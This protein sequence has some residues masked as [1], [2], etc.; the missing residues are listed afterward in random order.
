MDQAAKTV[1]KVFYDHFIAVFGVPAKLLSDRGQ[2]SHPPWWRN[3]VLLLASKRAK[4]Q[5]TTLSAMDR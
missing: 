2:T 1:V 4:P 5:P 3:F